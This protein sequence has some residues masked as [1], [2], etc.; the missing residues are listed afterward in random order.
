MRERI[1]SA[2]TSPR[3]NRTSSFWL[4]IAISISRSSWTN[5]RERR[6]DWCRCSLWANVDR[7][8][9]ESSPMVEV[10]NR[11]PK[12]ATLGYPS[13]NTPSQHERGPWLEQSI[14]RLLPDLAFPLQ[15][16]SLRQTRTISW[17]DWFVRSF[18]LKE[19]KS[20]QPTGIVSAYRFHRW[21]WCKSSGWEY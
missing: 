14:A 20:H 19:Q 6:V 7:L 18:L 21:M 2:V 11:L 13:R 4:H 15:W 8:L 9:V 5:T 17:I 12:Q 16:I 3:Q 1:L 10:G